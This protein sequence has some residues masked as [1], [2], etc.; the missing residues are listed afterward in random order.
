MEKK[1]KKKNND[2]YQPSGAG[3]TRSTPA[4]PHRLQHLTAQFIQNGRLGP[5]IGQTLD[6]WTL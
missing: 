1:W 3:G 2:E 4:T 6:Y 5:D